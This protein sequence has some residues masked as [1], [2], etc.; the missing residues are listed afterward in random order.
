MGKNN[1]THPYAPPRREKDSESES[2][3]EWE[4]IKYTHPVASDIPPGRGI[5]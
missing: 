2:E 5:S 1:Y 4:K 3:G